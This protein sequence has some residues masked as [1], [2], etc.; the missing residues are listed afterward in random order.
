[1]KTLPLPEEG[2]KRKKQAKAG[3]FLRRMR[4]AALASKL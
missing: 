4:R 1:M 2:I 3:D